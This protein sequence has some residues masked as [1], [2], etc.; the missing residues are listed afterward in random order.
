MTNETRRK[1]HG[2]LNLTAMII[3]AGGVLIMAGYGALYASF[4]GQLRDNT[5]DIVD[6]KVTQSAML[7]HEANVDAGIQQIN[8]RLDRAFIY[9]K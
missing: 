4:N 1:I 3:T 8:N 7:D 5:S 6:L 2:A 9:P